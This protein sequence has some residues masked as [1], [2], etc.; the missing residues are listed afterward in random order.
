MAIITTKQVTTFGRRAAALTKANKAQSKL[1]EEILDALLAGATL[2]TD[3]PY[4]I[5]LAQNGGKVLDWQLE[6]KK[7]YARYLKLQ[8]EYTSTQAN[9][10]AEA[11]VVAMK[12]SAPD[13][14]PLV[15][16]GVSYIGGVKFNPRI[17]PKPAAAAQPGVAA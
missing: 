15:I 17:N 11:K 12:A 4:V 10:L 8:N 6:F 16:G 3:G 2:P 5:E 9:A 1:R 13:K 14:E 7:L